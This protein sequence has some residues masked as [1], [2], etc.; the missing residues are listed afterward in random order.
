MDKNLFNRLTK[1]IED[2][3]S[4]KDGVKAPSRKFVVEN[5]DVKQ[6]RNNTHLSQVKFAKVIGVSVRTLQNWEQGKRKPTGTAR[7]LLTV[8]DRKPKAVIEALHIQ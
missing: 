4:I 5:V 6:I 3:G 8:F 7:I 1:S 2:A